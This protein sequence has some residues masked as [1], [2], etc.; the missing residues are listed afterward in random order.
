MAAGFLTFRPLSQLPVYNF[1]NT[2]GVSR[3][4]PVP[5]WPYG[6][7]M[8][9]P[10]EEGCPVLHEV[11]KGNPHRLAFHWPSSCTSWLNRRSGLKKDTEME[12]KELLKKEL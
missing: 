10:C 2:Q 7:G 8:S 5:F 1:E 3:R 6:G 4:L 9:K 12:H 11:E